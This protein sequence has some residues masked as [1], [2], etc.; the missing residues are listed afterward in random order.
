MATDMSH[1]KEI[2]RCYW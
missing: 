1:A 2:G